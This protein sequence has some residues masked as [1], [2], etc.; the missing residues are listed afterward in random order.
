MLEITSEYMYQ[1]LCRITCVLALEVILYHVYPS[2]RS[3]IIL[4]VS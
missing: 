1:N 2:V 4:H 3:H